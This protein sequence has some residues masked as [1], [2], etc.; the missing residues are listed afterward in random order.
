MYHK[1]YI[2]TYQYSYVISGLS[3]SWYQ[4]WQLPKLLYHS[5]PYHR[6]H[7]PLGIIPGCW[8]ALICSAVAGQQ[9]KLVLDKYLLYLLQYILQYS[10][11][12]RICKS[13]L[14]LFAVYSFTYQYIEIYDTVDK[15]FFG[16]HC[17]QPFFLAN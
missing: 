4:I 5:V 16:Y 12:R 15:V 2:H 17:V 13:I 7:K 1:P 3:L 14:I 10:F 8:P 6:S 9:Q 11:L